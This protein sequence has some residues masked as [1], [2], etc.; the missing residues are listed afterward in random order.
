M[1]EFRAV[2]AGFNHPGLVWVGSPNLDNLDSRR[3]LRR[4][5]HAG[6]AQV[7]AVLP[8]DLRKSVTEGFCEFRLVGT[9]LELIWVSL[10]LG[11]VG[12]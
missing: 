8:T 9:C 11:W 10:A 4:Y 12:I 1:P 6:F 7:G 2:G 5:E 3:G